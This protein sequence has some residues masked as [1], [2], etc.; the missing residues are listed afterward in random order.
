M[1]DFISFDDALK[2]SKNSAKMVLLGNGFS[3]A[4]GGGHFLYSHL[5]EKSGLPMDSPIR[6]VFAALDTFDFE[7]VMKALADASTIERAYGDDAKATKF[8]D[9]A[10]SVR[11]ALIK[12]IHEVHPK[13]TFEISDKQC[14]ACA[15][16]LENFD[17]VFTLNYDLLLYWVILK[18]IADHFKDGF[19]LSGDADGFREFVL[20][21]YCNTY[22]LH[23]ALHFFLGVSR[24]TFKRVRTGS[25][26]ID[27][28]QETIREYSILPL[29]VSEGTS[30]ITAMILSPHTTG[31]CLSLDIARLIAIRIFMMQSAER[32]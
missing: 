19:G 27:D 22:Y 29:F 10:A 1:A 17:N 11:E 5:L 6:R 12:A 30:E 16:F 15:S 23:G 2:A 9:D 26:I 14:E 8:S 18:N 24:E 31:P 32:R 13:V 20:G 3:I 25:T 21:A 4:Q 7:A 28:I